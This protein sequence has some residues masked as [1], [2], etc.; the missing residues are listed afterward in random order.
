MTGL[1]AP[2]DGQVRSFVA[3]RYGEAAVA[4]LAVAGA[5]EW[6]RAFA[7][8][9]A[10]APG[11]PVRDMVIRFGRHRADFAKD[12]IMGELVRAA[13]PAPGRFGGTPV[14]PVPRVLEI[15]ATPWG[16]FVTAERCRGGYLDDLDG[17]QLRG[18]LPDL[19]RVLAV[20]AELTPPGPGYGGWDAA[21]HAPWPAWREALL[22]V[23]DEHPRTAGWADRLATRPGPATV[24]RRGV[25][26]LADMLRQL[27]RRWPDGAPRRIVHGDLLNRNVLVDPEREHPVTAILDWGNA[28]YG[29]PLYDAAWLLFWQ[30]W[31]PAWTAVDIRSAIER[32]WRA[33]DP[34]P[35]D[36]DARLLAY[37][38]HIGLDSITYQAHTGRW[39]NLD[40][41]AD[42]VAGLLR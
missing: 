10:P 17:D 24:F 12:R 23:R 40:R 1:S 16:F 26:A 36:L 6:S 38:L 29:D 31:Y 33:A 25:D 27:E 2:T 35:D 22:S 28:M 41:A 30:P 20:V 13:A 5:G 8:R 11:E 34:P 7:L 18:V 14:V 39:A 4:S 9:A 37:Q 42:Q 3:G 19:L 15:G 32:Q 21:G